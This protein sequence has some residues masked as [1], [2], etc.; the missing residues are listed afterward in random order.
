MP[1]RE[2]RRDGA[3]DVHTGGASVKI[4]DLTRLI[5]EGMPTFPTVPP[6]KI[7]TLKDVRHGTPNLQLFT[8]PSHLG[9]HIDA[10]L[11][12]IPGGKT[13]DEIGLEKLVGHAVIVSAPKN[14]PEPL[15][16]ADVERCPVSPQASDLVFFST[17]WEDHYGSERYFQHPYISEELARWLVERRVSAV[18][19]DFL[20]ADMPYAMRPPGY[21]APAHKV[22]LGNEI[23]VIENLANLKSLAGRRLR[24]FALPMHVKGADGAPARIIALE[25]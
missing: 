21:A 7:E 19:V 18:G 3:R 25:D 24:V 1:D 8:F 6:P 17:G 2:P 4:V 23:P 14:G 12:F 20:S 22:L 15:R 11:H 10:P 5:Q 16:T 9:T 13:M